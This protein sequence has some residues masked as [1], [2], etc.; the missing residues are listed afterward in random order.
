MYNSIGIIIGKE[1][2]KMLR[3]KVP[4]QLYPRGRFSFIVSLF[5]F[6]IS[7]MENDN[8]LKTKIFQKSI[9]SFKRRNLKN[10]S[11]KSFLL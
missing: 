11:T 2:D 7:L 1:V 4:H 8:E 5:M 3:L 9:K 10:A 6:K